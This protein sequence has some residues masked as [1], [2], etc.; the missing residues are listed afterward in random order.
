[1]PVVA[2]S[3]PS[4]EQALSAAAERVRER[5]E[6]RRKEEEEI[7]RL[8]LVRKVFAAVELRT[9][10]NAQLD[11]Q[12]RIYKKVYKDGKVPYK[13]HVSNKAQKLAALL[14]A[15]QRN[16]PEKLDSTYFLELDLVMPVVTS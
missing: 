1:M 2:H 4:I 15:I 5:E 10:K 7:A 3:H 14:E 9:L 11:E 16:E 8:R 12:L 13:S 6:K